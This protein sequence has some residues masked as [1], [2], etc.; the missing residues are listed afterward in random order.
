MPFFVSYG[1]PVP[2]TTFADMISYLRFFASDARLRTLSA[3]PL[4][5]RG[6]AWANFYRETDS[7]PETMQNEALNAYL[8][9]LR[10]ADAQFAE[11]ATPGWRTDRGMVWLLFGQYD[12]AVDPF[13]SSADRSERGRTLLWE[14]RS[15]NL[16]VEF[17]R[18]G[19]FAQ[20][21]MTPA[22]EQNVRAAAKKQ[23]GG[24]IQR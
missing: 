2:T 7:N 9:R 1:E 16:S 5:G 23:F 4:Q 14:Y 6:M 10:Y 3:A 21:R 18:V 12:Q 19:A 13:G 15:L 20:W 11:G 17:I 24:D 22:S 8:E